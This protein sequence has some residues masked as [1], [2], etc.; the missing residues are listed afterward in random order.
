MMVFL[1]HLAFLHSNEDTCYKL[2]PNAIKTIPI[3]GML[4]EKDRTKDTQLISSLGPQV[5]VL[6]VWGRPLV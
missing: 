6:L 2:F 5:W 3:S 1:S 4:T